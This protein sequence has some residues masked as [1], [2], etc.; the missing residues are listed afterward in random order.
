MKPR[1]VNKMTLSASCQHFQD[2][3]WIKQKHEEFVEWILNFTQR[4]DQ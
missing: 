4:L 2:I 3:V 1:D